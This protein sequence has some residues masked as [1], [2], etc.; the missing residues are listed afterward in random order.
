MEGG[1]ADAE[2]DCGPESP[3]AGV[4]ETESVI[5]RRPSASD[6]PES[7]SRGRE[8]RA[9]LPAL[10]FVEDEE[11]VLAVGDDDGDE[12]RRGQRTGCR[13]NEEARGQEQ[14]AQDFRP[15]GHARLESRT[16]HSDRGE[17][18]RS[19]VE[20]G[21]RSRLVGAVECDGDAERYA[22]N[23]SGNVDSRHDVTLDGVRAERQS[24]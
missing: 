24:G 13:R 6:G 1:S 10:P 16:A 5:E 23:E 4:G 20:G 9:V 15:R 11:A 19:S 21:S 17:P 12:H 3:Q 8:N 22:Q 2:D 7:D 14:T 18:A